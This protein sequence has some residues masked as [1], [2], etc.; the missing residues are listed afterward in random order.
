MCMLQPHL[1]QSLTAHLPCLPAQSFRYILQHLRTLQSGA[2]GPALLP[3]SAVELQLLATE[4]DFYGLPDFSEVC[5]AAAAAATAGAATSTGA[6]G[7]GGGT[8][9]GGAAAAPAALV[10]VPVEAMLAAAQGT[11]MHAAASGVL[12]R[13]VQAARAAWLEHEAAWVS[14]AHLAVLRDLFLAHAI[15]MPLEAGQ[16][17]LQQALARP[18]AG[19]RIEV[20]MRFFR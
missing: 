1:L 18:V 13:S 19:T 2:G 14:N 6:R 16:V 10:P 8:D 15:V 11:R 9:A 12:L 7:G 4:A 3:A 20:S 5:A 17:D